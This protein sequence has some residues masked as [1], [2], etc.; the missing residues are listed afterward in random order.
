MKGQTMAEETIE[1]KLEWMTRQRDQLQAELDTLNP[2][3]DQMEQE[4]NDAQ[5]ALRS[6]QDKLQRIAGICN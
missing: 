6:A 4:R 1:Q 3:L 2:K 5:A